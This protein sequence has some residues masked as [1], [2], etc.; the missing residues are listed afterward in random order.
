[1]RRMKKT[2]IVVNTV[3]FHLHF[4]YV[5]IMLLVI[6]DLYIL[7]QQ[8]IFQDVFM[9]IVISFATLVQLYVN[10][11]FWL[12]AKMNREDDMKLKTHNVKALSIW[13]VSSILLLF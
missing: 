6:L 5:I 4:A 3:L 11:V 2:V 13:G 7:P 10:L 12:M 8:K 9:W 1:M